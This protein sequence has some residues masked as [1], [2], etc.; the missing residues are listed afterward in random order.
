MLEITPLQSP[1]LELMLLP[2]ILLPCCKTGFWLNIFVASWLK[3]TPLAMWNHSEVCILQWLTVATPISIGISILIV[4]KSTRNSTFPWKKPWTFGP[5]SWNVWIRTT[6]QYTSSKI[7]LKRLHNTRRIHVWYIYLHLVDSYG[8]CK[9]IYHTWI[10]R[11]R[12][13]AS[14]LEPTQSR[15]HLQ[16]LQFSTISSSHALAMRMAIPRWVSLLA[17][18]VLSKWSRIK[19]GRFPQGNW[20]DRCFFRGG[21]AMASLGDDNFH[22]LYFYTGV[23]QSS[24]NHRFLESQS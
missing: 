7:M 5:I 14:R 18:Y 24:K 6:V 15:N 8:K 2:W 19:C 11:D 3:K 9:W 1:A 16:L 10:Q 23:V 4:L 20:L 22:Y 21:V 12:T 13:S 17:F